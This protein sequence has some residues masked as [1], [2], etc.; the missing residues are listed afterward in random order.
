[1]NRAEYEKLA[2][3]F[4]LSRGAPLGQHNIIDVEALKA[5]RLRCFKVPVVDGDY[6]PNGVYWGFGRDA[7]R[8][9]FIGN[10]L[11]NIF[12]RARDRAQAKERAVAVAAE[13]CRHGNAPFST[14]LMKWV[15]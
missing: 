12:V 3:K 7:E 10:E 11:V 6:A 14:S 9:W 13:A 15:N 1:M 8:L 2:G 4:N 5:A